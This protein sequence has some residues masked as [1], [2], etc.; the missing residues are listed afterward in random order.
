MTIREK[1]TF[2]KSRRTSSRESRL[3]DWGSLYELLR[4]CTR[5]SSGH[6]NN[7]T[8]DCRGVAVTKYRL[9]GGIDGGGFSSRRPPLP[10]AFLDAKKRPHT[11]H[12][13]EI[14]LGIIIIVGQHYIITIIV[15]VFASLQVRLLYTQHVDSGGMD[16]GRVL[17]LCFIGGGLPSTIIMMILK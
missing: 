15:I 2:K 1:K 9:G 16:G 17:L 4:T 6:T 3:C 13:T 11:V 5:C 8:A 7:K 10:T 14:P 12:N